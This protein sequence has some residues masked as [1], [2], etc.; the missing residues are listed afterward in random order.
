MQVKF[1]L[2]DSLTS[3][4]VVRSDVIKGTIDTGIWSKGKT[5]F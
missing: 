3:S 5:K 2:I 4:L 1:D